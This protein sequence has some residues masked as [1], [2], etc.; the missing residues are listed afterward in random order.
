[1]PGKLEACR[2]KHGYTGI[3]STRVAQ[4]FVKGNRTAIYQGEPAIAA[5]ACP[6]LAINGWTRKF[7]TALLGGRKSS[8][9]A[10]YG[11]RRKEPHCERPACIS[12]FSELNDFFVPYCLDKSHGE[13]A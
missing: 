11:Q 8:K 7:D 4:R 5:H 3:L 13:V 1:M 12:F 2:C 9:K 6:G 10:K